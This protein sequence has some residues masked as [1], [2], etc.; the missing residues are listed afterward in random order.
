MPEKEVSLSSEFL[1]K[2]PALKSFSCSA[3]IS[4]PPSTS[5]YRTFIFIKRGYSLDSLEGFLKIDISLS[6]ATTTEISKQSQKR[7]IKDDRWP[8]GGK[9][10][11]QTDIYERLR[12]TIELTC[13]SLKHFSIFFLLSL[14]FSLENINLLRLV[15]CKACMCWW[16]VRKY[17]DRNNFYDF[18]IAINL[19]FPAQ[20]ILLNENATVKQTL[21]TEKRC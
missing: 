11:P 16:K 8:S 20:M 9:L 21:P 1:K 14:D 4:S 3:H 12:V 10:M 19:S 15:I 13:P 17:L 6:H 5:S 18:F 7:L 2:T